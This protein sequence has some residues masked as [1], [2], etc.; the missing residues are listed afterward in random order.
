MLFNFYKFFDLCIK[1]IDINYGLKKSFVNFLLVVFIDFVLY[2][3]Y[4]TSFF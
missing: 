4:V 2:D 1:Y 3:K